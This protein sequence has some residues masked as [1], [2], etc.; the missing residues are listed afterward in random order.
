MHVGPVPSPD[1]L[2]QYEQIQP[3]FAER[4]IS[5]AEKEQAAR[6]KNQDDLIQNDD[7]QHRREINTFRLGQAGAV[8]SVLLIIA[9]IGY[10]YYLGYRDEATAIAK[11]ALVALP[12]A[13]LINRFAASSRKK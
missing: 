7:K 10:V 11:I 5:M 13:F 12:T 4:L 8:L 6:L 2:Q 3:G 1:A 9:L